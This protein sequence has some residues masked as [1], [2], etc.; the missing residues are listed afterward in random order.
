MPSYAIEVTYRL[1]YKTFLLQMALAAMAAAV[2]PL[3]RMALATLAAAICPLNR[4][5]LATLAL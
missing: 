3:Y 1:D 2:C 4:M 5:A